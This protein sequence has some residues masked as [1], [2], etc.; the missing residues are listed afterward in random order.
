MGNVLVV[1]DMQNDFIT[2][3]LGTKEAQAILPMVAEKIKTYRNRGEE[4]V[5][6]RDTHD[7]GYLSTQEG[8]NLPVVHCIRGTK[9]HEVSDLLEVGESFIIDKPSFGSLELARHIADKKPKSIEL[10]GVCTDI[11][12]VSNALILKAMLPETPIRVDSK[13]CAGVSPHKHEAAL[14]T[15]RSCQI[16]VI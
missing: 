5:F 11:C 3:T 7:E 9:G 1:I 16:E 13:A 2:G 12:V 8:K 10:C 4:I 6:T 15:L 14:E